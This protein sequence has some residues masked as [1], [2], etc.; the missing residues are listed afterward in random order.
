M[1]DEMKKVQIMFEEIKSNVKAIAEGHA[2][3]L[4]A[5]NGVDNKLEDF[6]VE[7]NQNFKALSED[8]KQH[9]HQS[10]PPAH[11]AV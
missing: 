10:A 9:K 5:I 2:V 4:N 1:S 7:V 3:L 8:I 6:R 11:I